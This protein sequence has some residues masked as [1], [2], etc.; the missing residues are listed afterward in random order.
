MGP[1]ARVEV[2]R[3]R[4]TVGHMTEAAS[5]SRRFMASLLLVGAAFWYGVALVAVGLFFWMWGE[6]GLRAAGYA[7]FL[8]AVAL[9]T[10]V[11]MTFAATKTKGRK[12]L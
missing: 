12:E 8:F 3:A 11:A 7:G 4:V 9:G 10:G 2:K 5:P 6:D 1:S